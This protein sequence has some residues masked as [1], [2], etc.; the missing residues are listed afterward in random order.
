MRTGF[1]FA[2]VS[3]AAAFLTVGPIPTGR[4]S[5][6]HPVQITTEYDHSAHLAGRTYS[7]GRVTMQVPGYQDVVKAAVDKNLR[8]R[9]WQLVPTGGSATI[10]AT[11]DISS[12]PQMT[13][14]YSGP[15][16]G[17]GQGWGAQGWGPGWKPGYGEPTWNALSRAGNNLVIDIWDT[18]SRQ[19]LFRGV[20]DDDLSGVEKK[21]TKGLEQSLKKMFKKF[22]PKG[23]D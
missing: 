13:A 7:W 23:K 6:L 21:N 17:W 20:M 2:A 11:G 14:F 8:A 18:S 10:F 3:L 5:L 1:S 19:L 12:E 22:P 9:G 16:A 4:A 15:G